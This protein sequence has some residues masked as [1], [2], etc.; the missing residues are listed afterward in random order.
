MYTA[1]HPSCRSVTAAKPCSSGA[2]LTALD[3]AQTDPEAAK[4]VFEA[5][6]PITMIPLEV[7]Q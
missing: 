7:R 6:A 1:S 3:V 5:G 2:A 4:V